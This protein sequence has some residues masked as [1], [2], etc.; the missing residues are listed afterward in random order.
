M[1]KMENKSITYKSL[2]VFALILSLGFIISAGVMGYALKQFNSTKNSITVKGLA[3]KP[4]QAD[5]A[6]W[7]INLQT[8]HTS[9]TI[10]EAYQLL[11]QQMKELQAFFVQ[12]GFKAVDMQRGNK[13]S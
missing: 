1:L 11:D 6:R 5:S 13:S 4:I 2:W 8:N 10:P 9:G 12:H 7:E 3:E